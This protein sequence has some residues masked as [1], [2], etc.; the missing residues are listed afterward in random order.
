MVINESFLNKAYLDSC[1]THKSNHDGQSEEPS[2]AKKR[3]DMEQSMSSLHF[4]SQLF[5]TILPEH[6]GIKW[7]NMMENQQRKESLLADVI[8]DDEYVMQ[9]KR[10]MTP[11]VEVYHYQMPEDV[12]A[13]QLLA[14]QVV[15]EPVNELS[16]IVQLVHPLFGHDTDWLKLVNMHY[17]YAGRMNK[18]VMYDLADLCRADVLRFGRW[19]KQ[20]FEQQG[21]DYY[22]DII[23]PDKTVSREHGFLM[24]VKDTLYV[25]DLGTLL[26]NNE[27]DR[28]KGSTNGTALYRNGERSII[29]N[30][31][32]AWDEDTL[33][34][35]PGSR[36]VLSY[37]KL[38]LF[39]AENEQPEF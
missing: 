8:P 6:D 32:I 20:H 17:V 24:L 27:S 23:L 5:H 26:G 13:C 19:H 11:H 4:H 38:D 16:C 36:S 31:A 18:L 29:Q 7:K 28:N 2:S 25:V 21:R 10:F 35:L 34:L 15:K 14:P 30:Q 3:D 9:R 33:L 1:M 12:D 39:G 37:K 22:N